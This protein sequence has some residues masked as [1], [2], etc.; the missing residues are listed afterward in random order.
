MHTNGVTQH[1]I[2][3]P[4]S[5]ANWRGKDASWVAWMGGSRTCASSWGWGKG[6]IRC[7]GAPG[8]GIVSIAP[9]T[10]LRNLCIF[11]ESVSKGSCIDLVFSLQYVLSP[12]LLHV[13]VVSGVG[14]P[15]GLSRRSCPLSSPSR[16]QT[17]SVRLWPWGHRAWGLPGPPSGARERG[18]GGGPEE[19]L[20]SRGL[21]PG[22]ARDLLP[23]SAV[24]RERQP[25]PSSVISSSQQRYQLGN[26]PPFICH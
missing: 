22:E 24:G 5:R 21:P 8:R 26:G 16:E 2:L 11:P 10:C 7:P 14:T 23:Q 20:A 3:V 18:R 15:R 13:P 6:T 19:R 25:S 4:T 12:I 1:V 9:P 17:A